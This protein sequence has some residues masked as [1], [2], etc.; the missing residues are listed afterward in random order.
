M[1]SSR[2]ESLSHRGVNG[3]QTFGGT[4]IGAPTDR[5]YSQENKNTLHDRGAKEALSFI[6]T[7]QLDSAAHKAS[8]CLHQKHGLISLPGRDIQ[9]APTDCKLV[10]GQCNQ[11]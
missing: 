5:I 10:V 7:A 9:A 3:L 8:C 2:W 1:R 4:V 11:R 6:N